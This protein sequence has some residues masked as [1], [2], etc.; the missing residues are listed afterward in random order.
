MAQW[1]AFA[2]LTGVVLAL[3][4]VLSHLTT[5]AFEAGDGPGPTTDPAGASERVAGPRLDLSDQDEGRSVTAGR[6]DAEPAESSPSTEAVRGDEPSETAVGGSRTDESTERE[7]GESTEGERGESTEGERGES[8]EGERG[9]S[10]VRERG[11]STEGERGES[12]EREQG[13]P[14][15]GGS[16]DDEGTGTDG[17]AIRG[18]RTDDRGVE[19]ESLSTAALL[20][21][22]AVSQ[23]FFALVLIGGAI[24]TGIPAEALGI[25]FDRAY[26][27]EGLVVGVGLG[28]VLY[29]L[30]EVGA[31]GAKRAGI[32]LSEELRELLAPESAGGWLVLLFV[33]LPIIAV[34]EELLFRAALVGA[35]SVGFGISPWLLA[36]ASSIAFAVGHG[37]QG[38]A[39]VIVTGVL[40]FV[41]AAVFVLTGSL[42][43][44]VVAHYLINVLEFVVHE[45]LGI[46]PLGTTG[47]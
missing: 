4:L 10:V 29:A 33:V 5:A 17:P 25:A 31:A 27:R 13:E 45:G 28:V 6:T 3:L 47:S 38:T 46:D 40:G 18:E 39:G 24:Y 30:N 2:A 26:L 35:L 15:E 12:V 14:V 1:T 42:L 22:V 32:D 43:V 41:L 20:A 7:R 16:G 19:P 11:E 9:E 34:F 21:N 44:V 36:V 8:T 23:G 37:M